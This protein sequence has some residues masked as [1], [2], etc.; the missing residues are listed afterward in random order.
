MSKPVPFSARIAEKNYTF[1]GIISRS[2]TLKAGGTEVLTYLLVVNIGQHASNQ[3]NQED[4][5]EAEEILW[6]T[7]RQL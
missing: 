2:F 5:Q 6:T 4:Q 7:Q 1:K 3:L